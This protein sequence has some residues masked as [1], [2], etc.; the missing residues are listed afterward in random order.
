MAERVGREP[1]DHTGVSRGEGLPAS[2]HRVARHSPLD[3]SN[4]RLLITAGQRG[5]IFRPY[6]F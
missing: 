2:P 4:P 6:I 5:C 3:T 1:R